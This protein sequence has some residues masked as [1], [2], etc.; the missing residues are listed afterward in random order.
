MLSEHVEPSTGIEPASTSLRERYPTIRVPTAIAQSTRVPTAR[1]RGCTGR[2]RT[3]DSPLNR[4]MPCHLATVQHETVG[5]ASL[6][7]R[8]HTGTCAILVLFNCQRPR[9]S[10]AGA[11]GGQRDSG[12]G[13]E[14][15]LS[16]SE[17]EVLPLDDPERVTR[18]VRW[19][20]EESNLA[21]PV[22]SRMLRL[23]AEGPSSG[24][25]S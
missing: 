24:W 20:L 5:A 8:R 4:R 10:A 1:R 16:G 6:Q 21:L 22:K 15:A 7:E 2:I 18:Y 9:P 17:P 11:V 23:G 14:P 19:A 13:F 25:S 12:A 3:C